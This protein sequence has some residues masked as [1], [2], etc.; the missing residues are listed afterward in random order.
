MHKIYTRYR[1]RIPKINN[2]GENNYLKRNKI[3]KIIIVVA[4]AGLTVKTVL[5]AVMPIFDNLC[6]NRAKSVATIISNEQTTE[7]MKKHRY[8]ELFSIEKDNDGN[9]KMIKSNIISINEISSDIALK[10]QKE[11]DNKGRDKIGIAIGS[12]TGSK[13]LSGRGP[14]LK[15]QI[16]TVGNIETEIKSEFIAK[17]INQTLHRVYIKIKCQINILTP[18]DNITKEI[19]NEILLAENVIVGNI[20]ETYYSLEGLNEKN[21]LIELIK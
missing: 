7:V 4:I 16:S 19:T 17:G 5:G 8:E 20:P 18:F 14:E 10:I 13:L 21:D 6:E 3:V 2:M 12:F 15:I 9:I 1:F 11:I